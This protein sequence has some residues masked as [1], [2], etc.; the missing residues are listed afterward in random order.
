MRTSVYVGI[1]MLSLC[2]ANGCVT[3]PRP[4]PQNGVSLVPV[5]TRS[6]VREELQGFF[7]FL[8]ENGYLLYEPITGY[9]EGFREERE[10]DPETLEPIPEE[11]LDPKGELPDDIIQGL[12]QQRK[13]ISEDATRGK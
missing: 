10:L 4:T 5:T 8:M 11:T 2:S 1:L 3:T 7:S 6:V 9:P 13:E 12:K